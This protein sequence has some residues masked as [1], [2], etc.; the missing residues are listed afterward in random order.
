MENKEINF[1]MVSQLKSILSPKNSLIRSLD[2]L[3][4]LIT[5]KLLLERKEKEVWKKSKI[6]FNLK[7]ESGKFKGDLTILSG[8]TIICKKVT[9]E[10]QYHLYLQKL[11]W[12]HLMMSIFNKEWLFLKGFLLNAFTLMRLHQILFLR[13][14]YQFSRDKNYRQWKRNLEIN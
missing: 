1:L 4:S 5:L 14:F 8:F 10:H 6:N 7:T 2:F 11:K 13:H 9:L 12:D 3:T